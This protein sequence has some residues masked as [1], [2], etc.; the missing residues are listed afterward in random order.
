[1][2][3]RWFCYLCGTPTA[4]EPDELGHAYCLAHSNLRA[5]VDLLPPDPFES[6]PMQAASI[7]HWG[8][9]EDNKVEVTVYEDGTVETFDSRVERRRE[10][11]SPAKGTEA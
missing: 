4:R 9:A 11:S 1:M 3:R 6:L 7:A 5:R 10:D 8:V 2:R